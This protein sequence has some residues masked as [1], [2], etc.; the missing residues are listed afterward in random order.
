M[1]DRLDVFADTRA[2]YNALVGGAPYDTGDPDVGVADRNLFNQRARN[3]LYYTT[4]E[5]KRLRFSAAYIANQQRDDLP[6]SD[7]EA[8][9]D[10]FSFALV[11]ESGALYTGVAYERMGRPKGPA[12]DDADARKAALG[13]DFGEGTRVALI[14]EQASNGVKVGGRD[15]S[16]STWYANLSHV[17]GDVTYKAAYGEAADLRGLPESGAQMVALGFSYALSRRTDLYL[18]GAGVINGDNGLYA[19]QPD[20]DD[21][22]S[23]IAPAAAGNDVYAFS[24]GLVHRFDVGL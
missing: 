10:G 7:D 3:I 23:V 17:A 2:D 13:W 19:L 21:A 14:W 9:L 24:A 22:D 20:Q 1:T 16:R 18:L 11:F 5:D 6:L 4:P 8:E 12:Q 15:A